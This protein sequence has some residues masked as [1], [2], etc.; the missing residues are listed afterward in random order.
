MS[1]HWSGE[2]VL[3]L[4]NGDWLDITVNV[5]NANELYSSTWFK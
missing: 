4:D 2:K 5:R 1:S 3:E